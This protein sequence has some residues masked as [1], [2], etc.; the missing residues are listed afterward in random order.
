M[1]E[2]RGQ[3]DDARSLIDSRGLHGCDLMLTE[4]LK[5]DVEA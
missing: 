2:H 3:I 4:R 1:G 5:H